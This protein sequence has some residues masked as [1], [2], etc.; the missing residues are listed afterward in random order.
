MISIHT[1]KD[2]ISVYNDEVYKIIQKIDI[3]RKEGKEIDTISKSKP[4]FYLILL[5]ALFILTLLIFYV[6]K[7][8][9]YS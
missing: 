5:L 6:K 7:Y 2:D 9:Y 4:A 8:I 1:E 3:I